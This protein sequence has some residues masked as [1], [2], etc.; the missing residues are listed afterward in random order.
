MLWLSVPLYEKLVNNGLRFMSD[1]K[2]L[3]IL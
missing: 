2:F 1:K 3:L